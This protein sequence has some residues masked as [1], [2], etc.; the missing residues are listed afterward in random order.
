[1]AKFIFFKFSRW[2]SKA[3]KK[4]LGWF[5]EVVDS[6]AGYCNPIHL[7]FNQPVKGWMLPTMMRCHHPTRKLDRPNQKT[8]GGR[9]TQFGFIYSKNLDVQ[10]TIP[11]ASHQRWL[12]SVKPSIPF[13]GSGVHWYADLIHTRLTWWLVTWDRTISSRKPRKLTVGTRPL[14]GFQH[15]NMGISMNFLLLDDFPWEQSDSNSPKLP[16]VYYSASLSPGSAES[17]SI[18]W[19]HDWGR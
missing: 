8:V 4:C 10:K 9:F 7:T 3:D 5:F 16:G 14:H 15:E 13:W 2:G 19:C 6:M 17:G 11:K 18:S 1:M 12:W